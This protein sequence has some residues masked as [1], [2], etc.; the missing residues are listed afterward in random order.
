MASKKT[1]TKQV[2]A[3][4][5]ALRD[6]PVTMVAVNT[7]VQSALNVRKQAPDAAKLTELA[8][9]IKAVG[10]LQNMVAF[11][12]PDGLLAVAAG[13]RRL[14]ALQQL[15][16]AGDIDNDYLVPVKVVDEEMAVTLSLTENSHREDMHPADQIRAFMTLSESGK[17]AAQIG[18]VLGYTTRHVQKCLRLAGMA[19][20][21][22]EALATDTINLDQLQALSANEDHQR[23]LNVWQNALAG[24][25]YE[26]RPDALRREVLC[27]E[28][29]AENNHQLT[30]V[31][32]EA[33]EL[34]GGD[35]RYDLFTDEGFITDPALLERLT[36]EKL[37]AAAKEIAD[38]E[39]WKWSEGRLSMIR[40]YGEDAQ[41]YRLEPQPKAELTGVEHTQIAEWEAERNA[42]ADTEENIDRVMQL[43][44]NIEMLTEQAEN[45][46]WLYAD[47]IRG[48]VVASLTDGVLYIQRGVMLRVEADNTA[49]VSENTQ[50]EPLA[51][52]K[53][54]DNE[55]PRDPVE[56]IS[57][58]LLTRM[59][60]ERTLAV[61][62][63]LMQQNDKAVALLAWTL[64][65]GV[66][67]S[68]AY[69]KAAKINL[70]CQHYSLTNNAP[71][72]SEGVAYIALMQEKVRLEALL[73][74][75]WARD[76]TRFFTLDQTDLMA[77]LG[78]CVSCSLDGVQTRDMGHTSRSPLDTLE[79]ALDFHLRDWWQPT[80]A[81]F[82]DHLKKPQIIDA[83]NEAG[84][85][86]AARDADKMKK[87]DAAELAE[88]KM[89]SNR[90][91]PVWMYAPDAQKT[92]S[93]AQN[94][95]V[96]LDIASS[97]A[98][99]DVDTHIVN[100]A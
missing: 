35:F 93:D 8:E 16:A 74:S 27:D 11:A 86:G 55:S 68:G 26:Q 12:Q 60:S 63:A 38:V 70:D 50:Q 84:Q 20:A 90:W 75:G 3:V 85:T 87:G 58:P 41:Q 34:A 22:L 43:N 10:V 19:P 52:N 97:D 39:G 78:F 65:V 59:S 99:N 28:V 45:R 94:S 29:S 98:Q 95:P 21:L 25:S 81:N 37:H 73:P 17:T 36:R 49:N 92:E 18:S 4:N 14:A 48:G 96:A 51:I 88:S 7:L 13:G 31:G 33:Y 66:F 67:S 1:T 61:Q 40:P 83:L 89:G 64:C 71:S 6:I 77:L 9:S 53:N 80:K 44:E 24:Y 15:L 82:F 76:F 100:A 57:L 69:N 42:L 72:G 46:A 32:R 30:F 91:V 79:T 2:N 54:V 47:R 62:A 23:Q 56:A 5:T